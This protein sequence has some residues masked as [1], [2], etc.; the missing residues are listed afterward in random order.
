MARLEPNP[1]VE[2]ILPRVA[3]R[4]PRSMN[5]CI[6]Q[7]GGLVWSI[8]RRYVQPDSEAEDVVQ[9]AFAELWQK[10][11]RFDQS[12]A[13]AATFI[14]LIARRRSIDWLRR[15]SRRPKLQP[16]PPDF[17]ELVSAEATPDR[18][19]V[20]AENL[21]GAL[22]QLS[23]DARELFNLHFTRGLTHAEIAAQTGLP[24]GTIKTRLRRGL[25]DM[26]ALL[27]SPKAQAAES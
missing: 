4:D 8:I 5:D 23:S 12:R 22:S 18:A 14:G 11:D 7:F 26:R 10:A 21:Q 15:K 27:R 16:L 24:L 9:E 3:R 20:D 17:D 2:E 19:C 1:A 25:I 13:S 6:A